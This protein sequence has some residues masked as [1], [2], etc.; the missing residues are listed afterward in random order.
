MRCRFLV[1]LLVVAIFAVS[2]GGSGDNADQK[3]T[4][5]KVDETFACGKGTRP[6]TPDLVAEADKDAEPEYGGSLVY[7]VEA[8]SD[9]WDPSTNRFAISGLM[10]AS[11]VYDT[12]TKP[13]LDGQFKPWLAE[14]INS[15]AD[16][17]VWT[18]KLREGVQFHNGEP[19][20][21]DA[22]KQSLDQYRESVLTGT[23][24][25]NI[26][27]TVIV[28]DLTLDV[29]MNE[30]WYPFPQYLSSQVGI[31]VAPEM[32]TMSDDERKQ[33]PIG[34]GPF[35]FKEWIPD[36]HF[37]ATR[38]DNYWIEGQPYLDEVEFKPILDTRARQDS[39]LSGEI[40]IMH[41]F[42]P[43]TIEEFRQLA[44]NHELQAYESCY[45]GEDEEFLILLN[46]SKPPFDDEV[47][48]RAFARAVDTDQILETVF[49]DVFPIARGP[50]SPASPWY[51]KPT[52]EQ[53]A[54]TSYDPAEAKR[55][56]D[57]YKA[58]HDGQFSFTLGLPIGL[59]EA[60]ESMQLTQQYLQDVGMDVQLEEV[61]Q[62]QYIT[63]AVLGDYEAQIWR[64]FGEPD[65]DGSYV[66]WHPDNAE[67]DGEFSLNMARFDDPVIGEALDKA[68]STNDV[69]VRA[70][71]YGIVQDQFRDKLY[72]LW[73]AHAFWMVA[74]NNDVMNPTLWYLPDGESQG[75]PLIGGNHAIGQIWKKQ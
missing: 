75:V 21:A 41:T 72:L 62:A 40:D 36:N 65:P 14:E 55:L 27:D 66:W 44:V 19:L 42:T 67:P 43:G 22:V 15:N 17:T 24:L 46:N 58:D 5:E 70:E 50:Y 71:Q 32:W 4:D 68:R 73:S 48:R 51:K 20:T 60:R 18:I 30:P 1:A 7:G 37:V 28:D 13:A 64:Q 38:N 52:D 61:E 2:C 11:S 10:V 9:G 56:V 29:V 45:W 35:V 12:L 26:Q 33:N 63:N 74:A 8:E 34:T 53:I 49:D 31:V 54:A 6:D 39:L 59:P 16:A 25:T 47:A 57:E 69:A 3:A 23:A